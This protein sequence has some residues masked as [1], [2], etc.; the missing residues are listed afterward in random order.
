M[1]AR[2]STSERPARR[3]AAVSARRRGLLG[4]GLLR[5]AGAQ[6]DHLRDRRAADR[7]RPRPDQRARRGRLA[8]GQLQRRQPGRKLPLAAE[9]LEAGAPLRRPPR[10]GRGRRAALARGA[11]VALLGARHKRP[12]ALRRRARV[13]APRQGEPREPDQGGQARPRPRQPPL[14][15]LPRQLGLPALHTAGLQPARL[16]E[17]ARPARERANQLRET[18]PLPLHRRRGHG[19]PQ[20]PAARPAPLGRL[21]APQRLPRNAATHPRPRPSARLNAPTRPQTKTDQ[22]DAGTATAQTH[23][24]SVR[25]RHAPEIRPADR[26]PGQQQ[27]QKRSPPRPQPLTAGSG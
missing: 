19:R 9:E 26:D 5:R 11:R 12:G 22:A 20:R 10:P 21:P 15:K 17:A 2:R 8:A 4:S 14:P 25:P 7:L 24:A 3:G 6:A 1:K 18:A 23:A 13:V 27:D 16:A